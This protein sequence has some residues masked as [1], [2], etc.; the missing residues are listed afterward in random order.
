MLSVNYKGVLTMAVKKS[1]GRMAAGVMSAVIALLAISVL[2]P[3]VSTMT[4]SADDVEKD[5]AVNS[6]LSGHLSGA[7]K[8]DYYKIVA[9]SGTKLTVKTD[10]PDSAS[11]D[12]DLYIQKD[13]KPTTSSYLARGYTSSA[14]ETVSVSNPSGTYYVMVY[15]YKGS[16]DY[17]INAILETGNNGGNGGGSGG[18]NNGNVVELTSGIA[19]TGSLDASNTKAYYKITPG[20][21]TGLRIE[22]SG[23]ASADFDLFVKKNQMPSRNSYDY[24]SNGRGSQEKIVIS[25]PSG[26][27]Y[28]LVERYS[29][30]GQ[31]SIVAYVSVNAQRALPAVEKYL[32]ERTAAY[33][34]LYWNNYNPDYADYS[35]AGGDCANFGTQAQISGGLSIW[36]GTDGKGYGVIGCSPQGT[37]TYVENYHE[38]L[39]KQENVKFSYIVMD[40]D[41]RWNGT[42]PDYMTV[43]DVILIGYADGDHWV[44]TLT[45]VEG[46]GAGAK[47]NAHTNNRYHYPWDYYQ[48]Y[49]TR[50][51]FYHIE[52]QGTTTPKYVK[53]TSSTVNVRAGPSTAYPKIGT[54]YS[55]QI[56][57]ALE[58][59]TFNGA[60]WYKIWYDEKPGWISTAYASVI[61]NANYCMVSGKYANV[62]AQPD[63]YSTQVDTALKGQIFGV[64]DVV[65]IGTEL[66]A[67]IYFRGGEY[68]VQW[69]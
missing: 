1:K 59:V 56:Y 22:L 5:L 66:W 14:D 52:A 46:S 61:T 64:K 62:Y 8:K 12:F 58:T 13:A 7:G 55:G 20:T 15:D 24:R 41:G 69:T 57:I 27:Y 9:D 16:G 43:G 4:G 60:T 51:N 19:K 10:G 63:I 28:I 45:I 40:S 29:G 2:L 48:M 68:W 36:K 3:V 33:S 53:I 42:I 67:Q 25:N 11:V 6:M 49:F 26:T 34:D 18:S 54:V 37:I 35:S 30:S 38:H 31:Y 21:C 47:V 65:Y 17:T 50:Y 23:P 44:H 39:I 32:R